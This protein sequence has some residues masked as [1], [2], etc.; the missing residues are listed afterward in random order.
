MSR[1]N[2]KKLIVNADD[3]GLT[4]GVNQAAIECYKNGSI[5]SATLMVNA[6]AT[7]EAV[8]L[9]KENPGL[10]VGLHFN[11][12]IGKPLS[13]AKDIPTLVDSN[14]F[15]W[16]RKMFEKKAFLR[17][18][19]PKD[20]ETELLAQVK[21][22]RDFGLQM[23]HI[24]GHQ[25]CHLYP[26]VFSIL[27][28]YCYQTKTPIRIPRVHSIRNLGFSIRNSLKR[29]IRTDILKLLLKY[30][31][32]IAGKTLISNDYFHSIFDYTP[33]PETLKAEH[34]I[35]ILGN[36]RGGI[37][38]LM[39]HPA[40]VDSKLQ[41]LTKITHL[42]EQEYNILTSFSLGDECAKRNIELI[43]YGNLHR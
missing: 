36:L 35:R 17:S 21:Q 23:T 18:I 41:S 13:E 38:E 4:K 39:V 26:P 28:D 43:N 14:G 8:A 3:F 19:K 12:T 22:F 32:F 9:A 37:S 31:L 24:D 34:Y 29:I 7:E 10:G 2:T 40:I 1:V 6:D 27:S 33:L 20:V 15:F 30:N 11:L 16:R 25:H 5:S 42:S